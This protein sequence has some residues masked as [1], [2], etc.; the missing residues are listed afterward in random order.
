MKQVGG[1]LMSSRKIIDFA[2]ERDRA[3]GKV[4]AKALVE[5]LLSAVNE[6]KVESVV[7]IVKDK[8]EVL[9]IGNNSMQYT[10]VIGLLEV[11]KQIVINA[12]YE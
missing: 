2:E 12:M 9:N 11:G 5:N 4:T 3:N 1:I 6:G 7:Y 8:D 10:E